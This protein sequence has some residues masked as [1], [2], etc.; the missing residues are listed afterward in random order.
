MN[1]LFYDMYLNTYEEVLEQTEKVFNNYLANFSEYFELFEEYGIQLVIK[2]CYFYNNSFKTNNRKKGSCAFFRVQLF[3][4]RYTFAQ[5]EKNHCYKEMFSHRIIEFNSHKNQYR[6]KVYSSKDRILK[7]FLNK[8]LKKCSIAKKKGVSTLLPLKERL[9]D[10]FRSIFLMDRY[11]T[12]VKLTFYNFD[13]H[14]IILI[15]IIILTL[16]IC[17]HRAILRQSALEHIQRLFG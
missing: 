5:A 6:V 1:K 10:V 2:P 8:Y 11:R 3:P 13:L 7:R 17:W 16:I 9:A 12:R 15:I 14:W 4:K